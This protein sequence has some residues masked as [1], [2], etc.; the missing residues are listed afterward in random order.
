[1]RERCGYL[2]KRPLP[3]RHPVA[4]E[5]I[6]VGLWVWLWVRLYWFS[7]AKRHHRIRITGIIVSLAPVRLRRSHVEWMPANHDGSPRVG[8]SDAAE[9]TDG[10]WRTE[11]G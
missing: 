8:C 4:P 6:P 10:P 7:D 3:D 2:L 5:A 1:M 9:R 11:G